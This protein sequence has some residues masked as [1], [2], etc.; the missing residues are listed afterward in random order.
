MRGCAFA[1][2]TGFGTWE[3]HFSPAAYAGRVEEVFVGFGIGVSQV[4][5]I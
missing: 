1:A 4:G 2:P 3:A 5:V